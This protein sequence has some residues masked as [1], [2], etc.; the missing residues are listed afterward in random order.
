MNELLLTSSI[1]RREIGL[2]GTYTTCTLS[3]N[4][5]YLYQQ[6]LDIFVYSPKHFGRSSTRKWLFQVKGGTF[7]YKCLLTCPR[8][9]VVVRD[10]IVLQPQDICSSELVFNMLRLFICELERAKYHSVASDFESIANTRL[11]KQKLQDEKLKLKATLKIET[12]I[13]R[14]CS[15]TPRKIFNIDTM[16]SETIVSY[17]MA[18]DLVLVRSLLSP[19]S[20][21]SYLSSQKNRKS[22][23]DQC[24]GRRLQYIQLRNAMISHWVAFEVHEAGS[25]AKSQTATCKYIDIASACFQSSNFNALF[26]I[27]HGLRISSSYGYLCGRN[28]MAL[29]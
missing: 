4:I 13:L 2:R 24:A 8:I 17:L 3:T 27:M 22:V 7:G 21:R 28:G 19:E 15:S 12:E 29:K 23:I 1:A 26:C 11:N 6:V 5:I 10:W 14:F 20:I 18:L 25:M 16:D 9:I